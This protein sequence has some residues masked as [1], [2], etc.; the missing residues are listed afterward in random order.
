V[1]RD[2][3]LSHRSRRTATQKAVPQAGK[4]EESSFDMEKRT[5][6]RTFCKQKVVE[7]NYGCVQ[8]VVRTSERQNVRNVRKGDNCWD[9]KSTRD[10][11]EGVLPTVCTSS[12]SGRKR[13]RSFDLEKRTNFRTFC[14]HKVVENN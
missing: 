6:F 1:K 13:G 2:K 7:N 14:K 11:D 9:G 3:V 10:A 12:S 8:N 4:E 5:H